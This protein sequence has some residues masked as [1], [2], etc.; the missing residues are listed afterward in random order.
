MTCAA[1]NTVIR[2]VLIIR[3]LCRPQLQG[4]GVISSCVFHTTS[5]EK[6]HRNML[7]GH[8]KLCLL[9][10][11]NS[12]PLSLLPSCRVNS[13][14]EILGEFQRVGSNKTPVR[15]SDGKVRLKETVCTVACVCVL[16]CVSADP[17]SM[18]QLEPEPGEAEKQITAAQRR[19][20][21]RQ[22]EWK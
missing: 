1:E 18:S 8:H 3:R 17:A 4:D 10:C 20:W 15:K 14:T 21:S 12:L 2:K 19:A 5:V 6:H 9:N 13:H 16:V 11:L 7:Q 22:Q